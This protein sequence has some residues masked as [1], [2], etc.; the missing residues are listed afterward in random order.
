MKPSI[1]VTKD[2]ELSRGQKRKLKSLGIVTFHD[3]PATTP[4][5]WFA[6]CKEAD[7]IYT[8]KWHGFYSDRLYELENLF[9]SLSVVGIDTI[10]YNCIQYTY[11]YI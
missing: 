11:T 3:E 7:I 10:T 1:V 8:G 4:R 6:R 9:I 5:D 2:L